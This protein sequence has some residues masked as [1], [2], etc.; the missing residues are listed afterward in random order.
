MPFTGDPADAIAR[1]QARVARLERELQ[2]SRGTLESLRSELSAGQLGGRAR[3]HPVHKIKT[4]ESS[5]RTAQIEFAMAWSGQSTSGQCWKASSTA[6]CVT[7]LSSTPSRRSRGSQLVWPNGADFDPATPFTT[8]P[9][10]RQAWSRSRS[11]GGRRTRRES[12][13]T[14]SIRAVALRL[15]RGQ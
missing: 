8:G 2:E 11:V 15:R 12:Q 4:F 5:G 10:M 9:I 1:E 7:S 14:R 3:G 13:L 6:R